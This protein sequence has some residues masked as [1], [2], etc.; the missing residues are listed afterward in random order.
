LEFVPALPRTLAAVCRIRLPEGYRTDLPDAAHI[1]TSFATV[2]K[3][4]RF[5]GKELVIER[6]IVV[7]APKLPKAEWTRYKTWQKTA[8]WTASRGFN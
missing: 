4:Y 3:T 7:L 8:A 2:D 1:K 6:I 5:D